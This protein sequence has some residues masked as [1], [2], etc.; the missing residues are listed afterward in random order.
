MTGA[1]AEDAGMERVTQRDILSAV[2][3]VREELSERID[4]MTA[5][6]RRNREEHERRHLDETRVAIE[7]HAAIKQLDLGRQAIAGDVK[8][9]Q[10]TVAAHATF[11]A[12]L[13]GMGTMLKLVFGTSIIGALTGILALVVVVRDLS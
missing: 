6:M 11:W 5:E 12:E 7:D 8:S 13:K 10:A 9:L 2:N 1:T 4:K 3:A